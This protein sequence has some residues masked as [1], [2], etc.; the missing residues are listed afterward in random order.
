MAILLHE[1][2]FLDKATIYATDFNNHAIKRA[3]EGIYSAKDIKHYSKLYLSAGGKSSLSDYYHADYGAVIMNDSLKKRIT[4]ANHN[5]V[6]DKVFGEMNL[7]VCRNVLIYFDSALQGQVFQ[8]FRDSLCH[9]GFLALGSKE[10][11][12]FSSVSEQFEKADA[13]QKIYRKL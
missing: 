3:R 4:F 11:L 13:K 5:L 9:R 12:D 8:L 7:I 6:T 2:N 1:E 10:T